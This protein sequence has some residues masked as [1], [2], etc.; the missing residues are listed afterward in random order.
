VPSRLIFVALYV[1]CVLVATVVGMRETEPRTRARVSEEAWASAATL[2]AEW[3]MRPA[4]RLTLAAAGRRCAVSRM[5]ADFDADN[6]LDLAL[7]YPHSRTCDYWHTSG[8]YELKVLFGTGRQLTRT[9]EGDL[10]E[11][12]PVC[13]PLCQTFA[14]PDFDLDGRAE[15]AI[16]FGSGAS[17]VW[18]GVYRIARGSVRQLTVM[19]PGEERKPAEFRFFGSVCCGSDVVCRRAADGAALVVQSSY[20][21]GI[22]NLSYGEDVYVFDGNEFVFRSSREETRPFSNAAPSGRRCVRPNERLLGLDPFSV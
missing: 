8:R 10:S 20:G 7:V 12:G 4:D 21:Q 22:W 6:V 9:L 14:A 18:F 11:T 13:D 15:L 1:T 17:Q 16:L 19:R 3:G 2:R 5:V